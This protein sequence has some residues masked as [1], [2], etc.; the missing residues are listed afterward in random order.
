MPTAAAILSGTSG[1]IHLGPSW[2]NKTWRVRIVHLSY[3]VSPTPPATGNHIRIKWPSNFLPVGPE[4]SS[5]QLNSADITTANTLFETSTS[6]P[7]IINPDDDVFNQTSCIDLG[8]VY[9]TTDQVDLEILAWRPGFGT[10]PLSNAI[11]VYLVLE[12]S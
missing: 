3:L 2:L 1:T 11:N 6:Y 5:A 8:K 9:L 10:E 12:F 7:G 4:R